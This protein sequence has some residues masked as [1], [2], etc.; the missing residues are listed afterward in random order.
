MLNVIEV[1]S[2]SFLG[3]FCAILYQHKIQD[4]QKIQQLEYICVI[5]QSVW[6]SSGVFFLCFL[7]CYTF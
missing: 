5:G 6:N 2:S 4:K 3:A 7:R 1:K